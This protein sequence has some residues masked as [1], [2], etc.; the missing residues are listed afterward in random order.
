MLQLLAAQ[1]E[2]K[3]GQQQEHVWVDV[4]DICSKYRGR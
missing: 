4:S 1:L 2:S 3:A